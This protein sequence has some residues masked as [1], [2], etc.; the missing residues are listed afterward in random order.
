MLG[1]GVHRR[2]DIPRAARELSPQEGKLSYDKDKA[3][4]A[5][6]VQ[7]AELMQGRL[8]FGDFRGKGLSAV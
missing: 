5:K 3:T 6:L 2:A 4:I 1:E 7:V 8:A